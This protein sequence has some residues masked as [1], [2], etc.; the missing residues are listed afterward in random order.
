MNST[1][2]SVRLRTVLSDLENGRMSSIDAAALVRKMHFPVSADKTV[3]QRMADSY[4]SEMPPVA[5]PGSFREVAQAYH[6]GRITFQQYKAL[7]EAAA[8]AIK[9]DQGEEAGSNGEQST[10]QESGGSAGQPEVPA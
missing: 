6:A 2:Q 5:P 4:E 10:G 1:D 8:A 7:A 9:A 3:A